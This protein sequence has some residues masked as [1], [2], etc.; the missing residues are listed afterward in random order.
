MRDKFN[1]RDV[2][3]FFVV[4]L[5]FV[6]SHDHSLSIYRVTVFRLTTQYTSTSASTSTKY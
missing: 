6:S 4:L 5:P 3:Q 1:H 2:F